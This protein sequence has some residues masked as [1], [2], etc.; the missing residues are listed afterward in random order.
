MSNGKAV[1]VSHTVAGVWTFTLPGM[2]STT[3]RMVH[4]FASENGDDV[5]CAANAAG[6]GTSEVVTA[7]CFDALGK[8]AN[9]TVTV[10]YEAA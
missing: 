5:R 7:K 1:T 9:V 8:P 4:A 10:D 3:T 6:S 2:A